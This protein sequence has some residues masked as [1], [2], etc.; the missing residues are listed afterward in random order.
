M[1]RGSDNQTVDKD[2]TQD[3]QIK[4]RER[5][6]SEQPCFPPH[7]IL[8]HFIPPIKFSLVLE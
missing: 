7:S 2:M 5:R 1:A 4:L 8:S 6:S 3:A